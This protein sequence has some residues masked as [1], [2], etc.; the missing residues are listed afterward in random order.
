M[1]KN[2]IILTAHG[3]YCPQGDF[4]IDPIKPVA[5]AIIT[6]AHADHA[7]KGCDHYLTATPGLRLLQTRIGQY[8]NIQPLNY[9]E[10]I[11]INNVE[12]SLHPAGHILGS[13]QIRLV[14]EG[15]IWVVSGD[16]KLEPDATCAPF[17]SVPCH[18]FIT[19][20]T[21]GNPVYQ[22]PAQATVFAE[23]NQW[24][25]ANQAAGKTSI[26]LGYALGKAQRLLAG[27]NPEL[28]PIY[29]HTAIEKLNT[30]YRL[31]DIHLPDT[32]ALNFYNK[33]T[34]WDKALVLAPPSALQSGWQKH[35]THYNTA[36]ASGW[37]Q[38][39]F[40]RWQQN[41]D[42][43]F[44]LSDHA[45]WPSLLSAITRTGAEEIYVM[46]TESKHLVKHLQ[47]QG[48]NAHMIDKLSVE[49]KQL[50]LHL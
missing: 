50:E 5:R 3:L 18:T 37:M 6:H 43:G 40:R 32:L 11:Q 25:R 12:I 8:A 38:N 27:L 4:Y 26:L 47:Q 48:V 31:E 15:K 49:N 23:I 21:F 42:Q 1:M 19:E 14:Y 41:F 35:F 29:T 36:F 33:T 30:I 46:H 24:W 20:A 7:R 22:W 39:N 13:A 9:G 16:Y 2:L 34:A 45:D 17:E 10:K 44:I 28:G